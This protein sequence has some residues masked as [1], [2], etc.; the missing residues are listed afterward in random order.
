ELGQGVWLLNSHGF[1]E[2][3]AR[4]QATLEQIML[5]VVIRIDLHDFFV[6][7]LDVVSERFVLSL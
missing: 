3:T 7:S 6:E 2:I 4:A 5:H 1:G